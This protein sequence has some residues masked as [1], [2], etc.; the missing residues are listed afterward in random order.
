MKNK[1]ENDAVLG[2]IS[3]D[4]TGGKRIKEQHVYLLQILWYE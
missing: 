4:I 3:V 1:V 2:S